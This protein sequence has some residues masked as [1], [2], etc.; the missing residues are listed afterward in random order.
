MRVSASWNLREKR[1]SI[2]ATNGVQKGLVVM[3]AEKVLI[4]NASF[5][6]GVG[7]GRIVGTME[8]WSGDRTAAGDKI[9]VCDHNWLR[10]DRDYESFARSHG[11]NVF[12]LPTMHADFMAEERSDCGEIT[13]GPILKAEMAYLNATKKHGPR[14]LTFD[15]CDMLVA[16]RTD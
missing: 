13:R 3:H 1:F 9:L 10:S 4:R 15:P 2:T 8:G 16:A 6:P 5:L 11:V 12:Y 7:R 14:I